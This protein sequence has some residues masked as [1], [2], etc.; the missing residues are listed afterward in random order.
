[1]GMSDFRE[2][3]VSLSDS[4]AATK[5]WMECQPKILV[6][7]DLLSYDATNGFGLTQFVATLASSQIHG[8][9][10]VI[11]KAARGTLPGADIENFHFDDASHGVLISRYDVVFLF[12]YRSENDNQLPQLE[13][14][15]LARF[16]QAGGGVFAT[17]DH[18]SLGASISRDIPR[19]RSMRHWTEANTPDVADATRHST[20]T[21]G[22]DEQEDFSDQSDTSPQRLYLNFRT[23][24]GGLGMPHPLAQQI[25]PRRMLEVFPDHPHEG[26]CVVPADLTTTFDLDGVPT[27]E[28]PVA[29]V[30]P[31]RVSPEAV[32][33]SMS[34]GTG[35]PIGPT[36][37]KEPLVPRS[38]IAICAYDGQ[39]AGVGRVVTDATWHHF[40]NINLDGT[41]EAVLLGLREPDP[42]PANPPVETEALIRIRQY[43]RN[44]ATWLMPRTV[45]YC[46]STR[47]VV[48]DLGRFPL[49]EEV[50]V[51]PQADWTGQQMR[52]LGAA[53]AASLGRRLPPWEVAA[54]MQDALDRA[55]GPKAAARLA[56]LDAVSKT[57]AADL[58]LAALGGFTGGIVFALGSVKQVQRLRPH[59][60][61][62]RAV[63]EHAKQAVRLALDSKREEVE[64]LRG[65]L[66]RVEI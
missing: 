38:Y 5:L 26:E 44:L 55:V 50:D 29:E 16:M 48:A 63:A 15:A 6:V 65:A 23:E 40:V 21:G 12:G 49:F 62:D 43:Y 59:Q 42:N 61:F 54:L 56:A 45:R 39:R 51:P 60:A 66:K 22:A 58:R 53:V 19:V 3:L 24:A 28:W 47:Q 36:G 32:G 13:I 52:D 33:Y 57:A 11:V 31:T 14:D 25:P 8:M 20:N 18:D 30:M 64:A 46:L 27:D 1:M 37:P 10:P 41:G 7:T 4:D 2:P 9:T 35:F 17:G 34:H